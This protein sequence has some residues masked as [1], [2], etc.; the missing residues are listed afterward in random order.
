[1]E[2]KSRLSFLEVTEDETSTAVGE[3]DS[4]I[5][6][7]T[8]E[9]IEVA[10]IVIMDS[11][12]MTIEDLEEILVIDQKAASIAAKKDTLPKTANNVIYYIIQREN[13]G[14]STEIE[15]TIEE[16]IVITKEEADPEVVTDTENT[17]REVQAAQAEVEADK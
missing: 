1:M 12:N 14:N 10:E 3:E 9:D 6:V 4:T 17:E 15:T 11:E 5:E 2:N 8:E 16:E 13:L 7:E